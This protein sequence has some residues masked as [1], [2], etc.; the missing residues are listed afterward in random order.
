M[1]GWLLLVL[2]VNI[3]IGLSACSSSAATWSPWSS[4]DDS[5]S[6]TTHTHRSNQMGEAANSIA[7]SYKEANAIEQAANPPKSASSPPPPSSYD[8][9]IPVNVSWD[10]PV[11]PILKALINKTDYELKV[12]GHA[13]NMPIII[14][15]HQNNKPV[16]ELVRNI[17]L[18]CGHKANV[19]ILPQQKVVELR[20]QTQG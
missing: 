5:S 1:K 19:V 20:Y 15:L 6:Q 2:F 17:G 4:K 8:M 11:E 16:G 9:N 7:Q 10:G 18:Q 13:P 12:F 3:A 14:N